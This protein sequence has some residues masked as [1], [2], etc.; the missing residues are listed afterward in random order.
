MPEPQSA[1]VVRIG[2]EFL[3]R[4][5]SWLVLMKSQIHELTK[6]KQTQDIVNIDL[7]QNKYNAKNVLPIDS[8]YMITEAFQMLST[9]RW[10]IG[11]G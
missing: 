7:C 6:T 2:E 4:E 10:L 8:P 1:R 9:A 5:T 3:K 11:H